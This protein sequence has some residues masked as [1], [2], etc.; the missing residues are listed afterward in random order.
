M[1][2]NRFLILLVLSAVI[3]GC[4]GREDDLTDTDSA[5]T[6]SPLLLVTSPR[7][8]A[9]LNELTTVSGS[10][11][12]D[13]STKMITVFLAVD[14]ET[15]ESALVSR[16]NWQFGLNITNDGNYTLY[17]WA[18]DFAGNSCTVIERNVTVQ[19]PVPDTNAPNL[20]VNSPLNGSTIDALNTVSGTVWDD[21]GGLVTVFAAIDGTTNQ[22]YTFSGGSFSI[23]LNLTNEKDYSLYMWAKDGS[24]NTSAVQRIDVTVQIIIVDTNAPQLVIATPTNQQVL[25]QTVTV[26]GTGTDN[27]TSKPI[28]VYVLAEG[29]TN[30]T[31]FTSGANWSINLQFTTNGN[32]TIRAWATDHASNSSVPQNIDITVDSSALADWTVM[33]YLDADNNLE[34][35]GLDDF[36]EIEAVSELTGANINV[37]VLM[38]RISGHSSEDGNWTGAKIYRVTP[39]GNTS[40]IGSERLAC[41]SLGLTSISANGEEINMGDPTTLGKFVDFCQADY[42]ANRYFLILWNHGGG[43]REIGD[44]RDNLKTDIFKDVC[45]DD[46]SGESAYLYNY[47]VRESLTGKGIDVIGFDACLMGMIE[48]AYELAGVADY[49]IASPQTEPGGGWNYTYWLSDFLTTDLS[50]M[51]LMRVVVEAYAQEY[52]GEAAT[53]LAGYD[54]SQIGPVMTAL[55]NFALEMISLSNTWWSSWGVNYNNYA[56]QQLN[57]ALD[58]MERFDENYD[59]Y[60]LVDIADKSSSAALISA[61]SNF[62][63]YEWNNPSGDIFSGDPNSHGLAIYFGMN[64]EYIDDYRSVNRFNADSKWTDYLEALLEFPPYEFMGPGSRS[65]ALGINGSDF[66]QFYVNSTGTVDIDLNV[67]ASSDDDLYVF[68]DGVKL[69]ESEEWNEG[70]DES[71]FFTASETGWYIIEVFRYDSYDTGSQYT[72]TV[73]EG[74]ADIQ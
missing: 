38:D 12:D 33:V 28:T 40:S 9:V 53:T 54:L 15:N 26:T 4:G 41:S 29:V 44:K 32:Y 51:E 46:T 49:M 56:L 63:P 61:L 35:D 34:E 60:D 16:D 66:Y 43:W 48:V 58:T 74:T 39:D 14:G 24:G 36:N 31:Y 17:L 70:T 27:I 71:I 64:S 20:T 25:G 1:L 50:P 47:E 3:F 42:P 21:S 69:Y 22:T 68:Y 67:P 57:G 8:G 19:A 13:N 65:S 23:P 72:L 5:D 18:T 11:Y 73:S 45:W 37:I 62:I 30:T 10:V 55:D 7:E 2:K 59:L 52:S 6:V